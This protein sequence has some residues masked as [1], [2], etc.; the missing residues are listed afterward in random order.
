MGRAFF[1]CVQCSK[2]VSDADLEAGKAFRVGDQILCD[3][4]A[5][6]S[7]KREAS[8]RQIPA[9]QRQKNPGPITTK[10]SLPIPPPASP[11]MPVRTRAFLI[12]GAVAVLLTATVTMLLTR[13][14]EQS[15]DPRTQSPPSPDPREA[16]ARAELERA[17][18]FAKA[19]PEDLGGRM[20][21][22]SDLAAKW[23]GTAAADE[24]SA[25]SAALKTAIRQSVDT[26]MAQL[27]AEIKPLIDA[28]KYADA[29]RRVDDL[30]SSHDLP[31]WKQAAEKLASGLVELGR[32]L[33][34][35]SASAKK[36]PDPPAPPPDPKPDAKV[37]SEE[38]KRSLAAW[39]AAAAKATA[40]DYAGALADLDRALPALKDADLKA[41]AQEDAALLRKVAALVRDSTEELRKKPSGSG[42]ALRYRDA[43]GAVKRASGTVMQ[44]D[45]ERI[46]LRVGKECEFIDWSD[47]AAAFFAELGRKGNVE[48]ATLTALCLLEGDVETARSF[49]V[50]LPAKWW[51]YAE[52]ARARIPKPDPAERSAR[53]VFASAEKNYRTMETRAAAIEGYRSL[54]AD[55]AA[56][57][58]VKTYA[59]RLSRR[60]EAGKEYWIPPSQIRAD[61]S[62]RLA[63]S[64]KLESTKDSEGADTLHNTADVEFAVLPGQSYRSWIWV[65]ACCEETFQFFYQGS[66]LT[67]TDPKTKK[68]VACEPGSGFVVTVKHSI[69]NL[70]KTHQDHK[71]KGAAV[72]PKTAA[73]WEWVEVTL[74]KYAG[75]GAKKLRFLTNQAGFSI[76]GVVISSVRKLPPAEAELKDLEKARA[77]DEP[78]LEIDPDLLAWWTFDEGQG[79]VAKDRSGN[80]HDGKLVGDVK[81]GE[82]KV[83]GGIHCEGGKSGISVADAEDLRIPGDLTMALWVRKAAEPSDWTCVLGRGTWERRNYGLWLDART[84]KYM[85][86]QYDAAGGKA[87]AV[88]VSGNKP[89]EVGKWVHLA[90][91][92]E[93]D[94][95]RVYFDGE[96]DG[97]GKRS[98][99][100]WC[101][102]A[103]L[104]IGYAMMHVGLKGDL[105]DA[106]LY[107]R[108]L[109]AAE[110][111]ALY[112]QGR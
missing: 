76:G 69:R 10:K 30:K 22:F 81:W 23:P 73:R 89:I 12:G 92:I 43:T 25:E 2:R 109:T 9:V 44:V 47:A 21:R 39:E 101:G 16:S 46:E 97:Q 29:A 96:L 84:P 4:C 24:A 18:D 19:H 31:D 107:R 53:T 85:W 64:G 80:G 32:K 91:T 63:K 7:A 6:A 20:G 68:K 95:I 72:H 35:E 54:R 77:L 49:Q 79:S 3:A 34:E 56:T 103:P 90:A 62:F 110:I 99:A 70:K 87:S 102:E 27:H 48:P 51:T 112:D 94:Q 111:R 36:T 93:Q 37:A 108:A 83:G 57:A 42:L 5:P 1:Y 26:W 41:E 61:G 82:G 104:G 78:S 13:N 38:T 86:Q 45:S 40:R 75:P 100:P 74:P 50:A 15:R 8:S 105:D 33:E 60:S 88:N 52:G 28:K 65:G 106:R 67:D 14:A 55:F 66:D 17:R 59:E 58:L 98:D 71:I 11:A